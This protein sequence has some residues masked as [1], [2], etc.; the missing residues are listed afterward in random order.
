MKERDAHESSGELGRDL[1]W[2]GTWAQRAQHGKV[3]RRGKDDT[4]VTRARKPPWY[5]PAAPQDTGR[6]AMSVRLTVHRVPRLSQNHKSVLS[7]SLPFG[8]SCSSFIFS[9]WP[10]DRIDTCPPLHR[11]LPSP[12]LLMEMP[13]TPPSEAERGSDSRPPLVLL[14]CLFLPQDQSFGPP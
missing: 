5:S 10:A 14:T 12:P 3:G 9:R 7:A 13:P 1:A 11:H 6:G 2:Q 4:L 8:R